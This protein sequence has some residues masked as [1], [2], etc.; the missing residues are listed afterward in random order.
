MEAA[1]RAGRYEEGA[2]AGIR[3]ITALLAQHFPPGE[4][5]PDELPDKPVVL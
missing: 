2:L 3:E 1:F 4:R 5:N